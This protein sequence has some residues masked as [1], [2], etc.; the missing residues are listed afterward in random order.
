MA[1][2]LI[3]RLY[4]N[5]RQVYLPPPEMSTYASGLTFA[6]NTVLGNVGAELGSETDVDETLSNSKNQ[7]MSHLLRKRFPVVLRVGADEDAQEIEMNNLN[8]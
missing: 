4:L 1:T 2:I 5:L 7:R 8:N 3:N 6:T